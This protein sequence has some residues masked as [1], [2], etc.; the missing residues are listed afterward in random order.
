MP[1]FILISFR[2]R[3]IYRAQASESASF[4]TC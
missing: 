1:N 4:W 2:I 3:L